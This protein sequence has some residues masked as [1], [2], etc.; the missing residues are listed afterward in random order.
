MVF[1]LWQSQI[2]IHGLLLAVSSPQTSSVAAASPASLSCQR[3]G[4]A[5][6][7][8]SPASHPVS[9]LGLRHLPAVSHRQTGQ[10]KRVTPHTSPGNT[11]PLSA[12]LGVSAEQWVLQRTLGSV[13]LEGAHTM[14]PVGQ[15]DLSCLNMSISSKAK[16]SP[17][18]HEGVSDLQGAGGCCECLK[19]KGQK[20]LCSM[21]NRAQTGP[22]PSFCG[23]SS[24]WR[25]SAALEIRQWHY[26]RLVMAVYCFSEGT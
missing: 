1:L 7:K 24:Q 11:G 25:N 13:W 20:T 22:Q 19:L 26:A 4:T 3:L 9:H 10:A 21:S 14:K 5:S 15:M 23:S 17:D 16:S 6:W 8:T 2:L 12:T 18:R